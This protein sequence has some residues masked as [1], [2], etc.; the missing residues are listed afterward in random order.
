[1]FQHHPDRKLIVRPGAS[2]DQGRIFVRPPRDEP[3]T[4]AGQV[5]NINEVTEP[6]DIIYVDLAH[7]KEVYIYRKQ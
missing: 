3:T 5:F 1:M 4:C 7:R 2:I 6:D